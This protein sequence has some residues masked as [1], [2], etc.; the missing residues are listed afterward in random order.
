MPRK[1]Y[2]CLL[3]V[4]CL[5]GG[6]SSDSPQ[7]QLNDAV[8]QLQRNLDERATSAVLAQLHEDFRAQGE[9]DRDWV[10][11]TLAQLFVQ[12][13]RVRFITLGRI[14][15]VDRNYAD[16]GHT[17]AELALTGGDD[18][19]PERRRNRPYSVSLEW[20]RDGDTWKLARLDWR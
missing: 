6:C 11:R 14:S 15:R 1:L 7:D 8:R 12:Q 3:C 20:R 2:L 16:V 17:R 19:L 10:R 4:I 13:P 18:L 9:Y 5:L